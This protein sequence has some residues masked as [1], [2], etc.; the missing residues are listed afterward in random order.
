MSNGARHAI[1][2]VIGLIVTPVIAVSLLFGIERMTRYFRYFMQG[3][4]G[5]WGAAAALVFAAILI[6]VVAGSRLS[7][8]ASLVPGAFFSGVG[9]LWIAAPRWSLEH[10]SRKLPE[11]LDRGYQLIGPYGVL[12]VLGVALLA[13]SAAPS[14]WQART[15]TGAAPRYGPP[16]APMGPPG[17][18][19]AGAPRPMGA[20]PA[21]GHVPQGALGQEPQWQQPPPQFGPP[22]GQFG[23]PG[24]PGPQAPPPGQ[25]SPGAPPAPPAGSPAP[26]PPPAAGSRGAEESK[27]KP[28]SQ[29]GSGDDDAPGE[30]TQMY[31]GDD[32]RGGGRS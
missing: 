14:R 10:T 6:G 26:P 32:L 24:A 19:M 16:P 29:S 21:P 20:P 27:P 2:V 31:G 28:S 17:G 23:Q 11:T 8:L 3:D 18:P 30:W 25:Y 7:P 12:L 4:S 5:R 1:G 9:L 15:A 13:A 22:G